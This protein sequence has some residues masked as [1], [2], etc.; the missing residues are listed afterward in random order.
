MLKPLLP[1]FLIAGPALAEMDLTSQVPGLA[2]A[3]LDDVPNSPMD[4][5]DREG[6][7]HKL[8]GGPTTPAGEVA[9][10]QG[11]GVTAEVPLGDLTAVSFVGRFGQGTSGSCELLDGNLGLF[12]GDRLQAV[13]YATD[14]EKTLIGF[15]VPFGDGGLRLWSGDFLPVPL[16][17][18][19]RTASGGIAVVP[20]AQREPVCNGAAELPLMYGLPID[21]ARALLIA[22]GWQPVTG[23]TNTAS[24]AAEIAAAGVPEVEDC[25]GTGFGYCAYRY[26]GAAGTLNVTTMGEIGEDGSL[27]MV[28]DYG[29]DCR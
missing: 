29:M 19:Q 8:V 23:Q 25:S 1:L 2:I 11:W 7:S 20:L 3:A 10:F 6:C 13:I 16:A 24:Y 9:H 15:A 21:R 17:D 28:T 4:Q 18:V 26:T 12:A 5:G 14:P 22:E 27:P